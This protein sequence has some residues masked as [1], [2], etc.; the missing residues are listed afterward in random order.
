MPP[1]EN[2]ETQHEQPNTGKGADDGPGPDGD[3]GKT[4][5]QTQVD[6]LVKREKASAER[7][8]RQALAD[9]LGVS[10]DEVKR[11]IENQKAA[12][13][14]QKT[15]AQKATDAANAA[16]A[17]AEAAKSEAR[18]SMLRAELKTALL[19][20]SDDEPAIRRDR[21]AQA[22]SLL[23]PKL[24]G[25]DGADVADAIAD[26]VAAFRVEVPEFFGP[27]GSNGSGNGNGDGSGTPPGPGRKLNERAGGGAGQKSRAQIEYEKIQARSTMRKLPGS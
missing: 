7:K 22:E 5:T 14:A 4:L 20:G 3:Q 24:A 8:T 13:E 17:E 1:D 2:E 12:D 16:R 18:Q 25:L 15:E 23:L 27:A 19:G 10:I 9:E 6:Q 11:I 21:V 26:A